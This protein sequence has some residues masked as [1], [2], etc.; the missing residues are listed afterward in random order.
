MSNELLLA[1]AL[2]G[3]LRT[4]ASSRANQW[5]GLTTLNSGDATVVVSTTAVRSNSIIRF[6]AQSTTRQASGT[7]IGLEV[8]TVIDGGS[9]TFATAD[10]IAFGRDTTIMWEI[11]N[12]SD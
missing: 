7:R 4:R 10:G 11:L 12:T 8:S 3:P 5:A 9:F 2:R 1:P 6:G